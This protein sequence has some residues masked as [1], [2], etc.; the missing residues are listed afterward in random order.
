MK[1]THL[2]PYLLWFAAIQGIAPEKKIELHQHISSIEHLYQRSDEEVTEIS[3]LIEHPLSE[4][5]LSI[6]HG[7]RFQSIS[8]IHNLPS[9][10][11]QHH[12]HV[13]L[14]NSHSY[15]TSLLDIASPPYALYYKGALPL[16]SSASTAIVGARRCTAYGE[17]QA[18]E[19][20]ES[21]AEKGVQIISGLAYGIDSF[22]HRGALN[23]GGKTYAILGCGVDICYPRSNI[24]LYSNILEEGGGIISEYPPGTPP[25]H[26]HFPQRNRIISALSD[27]VLVMEAKAKSGSLITVDVALEQGKEVFA[28]P[29]PIHS[30]LS[31]G[32]N[33]LIRQG[34]GILLS[35]EQL[36][37]DMSMIN[38]KWEVLSPNYK[39][40]QK[41]INCHD[42]KLQETYIE[43]MDADSSLISLLQGGPKTTEQ[44]H[45]I[46]GIPIQELISQLMTLSLGGKIREIARGC[47]MHVR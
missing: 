5:E 40:K 6:L 41:S 16:E 22:G 3:Q 29:G 24:G 8:E 26:Y 13:A 23:G 27:V 30:A 28:L 14:W 19:F 43:D 38:E 7:A 15:P 12:I 44:L 17:S 1:Q 37:D 9:I 20:S 46:T 25:L 39:E 47:Y 2:D 32:C 33:Q 42:I 45:S 35:T 18:L 21:L 34:A 10:L 36:M 4:L 11:E 31:Q